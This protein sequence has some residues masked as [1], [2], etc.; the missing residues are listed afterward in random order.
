MNSGRDWD[1]DRALLEAGI[2]PKTV[3]DEMA[4]EGMAFLKMKH[5]P[6]ELVAPRPAVAQDNGCGTR[7]PSIKSRFKKRK[8]R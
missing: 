5:K 8:A 4:I 6:V 1:M 2:R 3:E 7:C